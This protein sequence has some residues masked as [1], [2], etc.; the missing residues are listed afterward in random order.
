MADSV[1][2]KNPLAIIGNEEAVI[3]FKAIGFKVFAVSSESEF[4]SSFEEVLGTGCV[5]CLIQEDMF[6]ENYGQ[7]SLFKN[8]PLPVFIPFNKSAKSAVLDKMTREMRLRATGTY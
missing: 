2:S 6:E 1:V 3:G 8:V 5:V 4:K 7:I